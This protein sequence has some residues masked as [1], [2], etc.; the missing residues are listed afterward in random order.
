MILRPEEAQHL[1]GQ[2]FN[3]IRTISKWWQ[4]YLDDVKPVIQVFS[5]SAFPEPFFEVCISSGNNADIGLSCLLISDTFV[6]MVLQKT[7]KF[8]LYRHREIS[9]LIQ[10]QGSTLTACNT[11]CIV[12]QGACEGAFCMTE[13]FTFKKLQI[14]GRAGNDPKG[15][16]SSVAPC[17]DGRG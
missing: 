3:I 7:K 5:K 9:D 13:E 11:A 12:T 14:K 10:K 6:F 4:L 2:E 15:F 16:C 8:G 17:M 1:S